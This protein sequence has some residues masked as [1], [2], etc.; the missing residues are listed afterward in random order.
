MTSPPG[1]LG[2]LGGTFDPPHLGHAMVP[3]YVRL[4]GLADRVLV[5]PCADHPLGKP[6]S[7]FPQR[8]ALTR[9]AME[10]LGETVQVSDIEDRLVRMH[11]GPSYTLRMLEAVAAE[12]PGLT[13][14][15]V[16]G[17]DIL[18]EVA[19][20]HR[21][22]EIEARFSPIVV[23]RA[24]HAPSEAC[25]LPEVSS[26]QVRQWLRDGGPRAQA[27]LSATVP[28]AVLAMLRRSPSGSVWLVGHGNVAG[29]AG[30]WL[31]AAGR[32]VEPIG[33]RALLDGTASRP[34]QE[35]A[36]I[37]LLATDP[38][39]EAVARALAAWELPR[40]VPVLHGAGAR[41]AHEVLGPL[42][43]RGHPVGTLHPICSL[44]AERIASSRLHEA[45]FG[46]E[47]DG[48]AR[49]LAQAWVG[50]QPWLDLQGLSATGRRAYHAACA[51]AANHLAVPYVAARDVLVGQ[52]HA[53]A[54]VDEALGTLLRS[55]LDNLLAL[56]V[57]A[58]IT[59]PVVRGDEA[60][61]AAHVAALPEPTAA[62]YRVL[63]GRLS[64]IVRA[65]AHSDP[66]GDGST[67]S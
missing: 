19:Q 41:L 4:R 59:G 12:H 65:R 54:T 53:E 52:G 36:G 56:G 27:G 48:P 10:P 8:L 57:P 5:V 25:V 35:P 23:P 51:L 2:V 43:E 39:I 64:D 21:W 33:A 26:T 13:V 3:A 22:S 62:L 18:A 9:A 55:A 38:A 46:I 28:A 15:L 63:S 7:P 16:V 60:A 11:G 58:G 17:T 42:A 29:H 47:G 24:G 40:T 34:P 30:P 61:V 44:R 66:A 45:A 50:S 31:R 67:V 20:W 49:E 1:V 32:G 37:W 6:M 14:R